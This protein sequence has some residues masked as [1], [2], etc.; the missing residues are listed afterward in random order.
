MSEITLQELIDKVR[1]DLFGPYQDT[2][3]EG[4]QVYPLFLVDQVELEVAVNVTRGGEGGLK[5]SLIPQVLDVEG[6]GGVDR[7]TGHTMKITLSPILTREEMRELL[8]ERILQGVREASKV[9]Y[10][11]EEGRLGDD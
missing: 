1:S 11:G 3:L 4:K 9:L 6:K 5:V 8:G 10:K 7:S 2:E